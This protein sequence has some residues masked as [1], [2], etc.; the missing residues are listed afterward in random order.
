MSRF[1]GGVMIV[2]FVSEGK[3]GA[4]VEKDFQSIALYR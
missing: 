2:V 3:K 1:R 4:G